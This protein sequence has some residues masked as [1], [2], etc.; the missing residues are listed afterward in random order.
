[1]ADALHAA[2]VFEGNAPKPG[3]PIHRCQH[4]LRQP[5]RILAPSCR[6]PGGQPL[7]WALL[8]G[9]IGDPIARQMPV[10]PPSGTPVRYV[11][12]PTTQPQRWPVNAA[13]TLQRRML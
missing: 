8:D 12:A 4:S 2:K 11:S 7:A 3:E 6:A 5:K 10:Y 1:M 9:Q 13:R